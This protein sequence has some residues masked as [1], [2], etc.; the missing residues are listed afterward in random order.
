MIHHVH[1]QNTPS[2]IKLG[3]TLRP[4]SPTGCLVFLLANKTRLWSFNGSMPA[5]EDKP[6]RKEK[7]TSP[8]FV[9]VCG[10]C[11]LLVLAGVLIEN[12]PIFWM[13]NLSP[14]HPTL[15]RLPKQC[16]R[17]LI[18]R[19]RIYYFLWS[20]IHQILS[21]VE[22]AICN[23]MT[24]WEATFEIFVLWFSVQSCTYTVRN[25]TR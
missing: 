5:I 21:R 24:G 8:L 13:S 3:S 1:V 18:F 14:L 19:A 6:K 22:C 9:S 11:Q 20:R 15:T 7:T 10:M 4:S 16:S 25:I 12:E 23:E 2:Y 17:N